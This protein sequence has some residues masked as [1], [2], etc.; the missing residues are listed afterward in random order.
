MKALFVTLL[1]SLG[2]FLISA[3]STEPEPPAKVLD[4]SSYEALEKSAESLAGGLS[5]EEARRF[6]EALTLVAVEVKG[7]Q[8]RV[9]SA[10]NPFEMAHAFYRVCLREGSAELLRRLDGKN[11]AQLAQETSELRS[12]VSK[13]P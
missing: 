8:D 12:T 5:E 2:V 9:Q 13:A 10:I 6:R 7:V 4:A 1:L 11:A 3:C